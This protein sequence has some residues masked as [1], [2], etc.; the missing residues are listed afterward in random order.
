MNPLSDIGNLVAKTLTGDAR[1]QLEAAVKPEVDQSAIANVSLNSTIDLHGLF[2]VVTTK[3]GIWDA[4][5]GQAT[6]RNPFT[7]ISKFFQSADTGGVAGNSI[8]AILLSLA[9]K[10]RQQLAGKVD[11][12]KNLQVPGPGASTQDQANYDSTKVQLMADIQS[13]QN[14]ISQI[15]TM[16]TNVEKTDNDTNMSIARNLA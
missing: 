9:S 11:Q 3:P 7:D 16:A 5:Q 4:I 2:S 13:I 10:E 1:A 14:S 8:T 6:L 12:L 15:T